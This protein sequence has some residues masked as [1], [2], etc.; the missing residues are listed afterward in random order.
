MSNDLIRASKEA[1]DKVYPPLW[2]IWAMSDRREGYNLRA[3]CTTQSIADRKRKYINGFEEIIH[4]RVDKVVA[5]H[6]F[7]VGMIQRMAGR[8]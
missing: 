2:L 7:G 3:I 4:V 6:M 1:S 5:N 8:V